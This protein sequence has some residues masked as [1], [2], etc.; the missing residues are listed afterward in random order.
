MF[1]SLAAF[2]FSPAVFTPLLARLY[3][4]YR[5]VVSMLFC[6][7]VLPGVHGIAQRHDI[8]RSI[9]RFRAL[10]RFLGRWGGFSVE[11]GTS[12]RSY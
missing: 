8:S 11:H 2:S 7:P 6:A 9:T 1:R 12:L 3:V 5:P 10:V 4:R